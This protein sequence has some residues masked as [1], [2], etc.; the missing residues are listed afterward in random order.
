ME[1]ERREESTRNNLHGIEDGKQKES[2][3]NY[4]IEGRKIEETH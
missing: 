1:A 3:R 2:E 4:E